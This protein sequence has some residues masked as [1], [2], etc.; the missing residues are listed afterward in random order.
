MKQ[1]FQN[2]CMTQILCF[3]SSKQNSQYEESP[4]G[5]GIHPES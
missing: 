3:G 4:P 2:V 5:Q 1:V